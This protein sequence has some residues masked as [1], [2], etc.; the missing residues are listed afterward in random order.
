VH[1]HIASIVEHSVVGERVLTPQGLA[2]VGLG[3][4]CL[5]AVTPQ[6]AGE[7]GA[8]LRPEFGA[9]EATDLMHL[10]DNHQ[11]VRGL[12]E[13]RFKDPHSGKPY[14]LQISHR[15]LFAFYEQRFLLE[16]ELPANLMG[17]FSRGVAEL[18]EQG[19][20][21][22]RVL[23]GYKELRERY[24]QKLDQLMQL[25]TR[26]GHS[27]DSRAPDVAGMPDVALMV[28]DLVEE[29]Q[30]LWRLLPWTLKQSVRPVRN[31]NAELV[32]C[33]DPQPSHTL[34]FAM[35]PQTGEVV[36]E[37]LQRYDPSNPHKS[38]ESIVQLRQALALSYVQPHHSCAMA[39][40]LS[41]SAFIEHYPSLIAP[42]GQQEAVHGD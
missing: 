39:S 41:A 3:R 37:H 11:L 34:L 32:S 20:V 12:L 35:R 42:L 18:L 33:A 23:S 5:D 28:E 10:K 29:M 13:L 31:E 38:L 16:P 22:L 19:Y 36:Y 7:L 27:T 26:E 2:D 1:D 15:L 14:L 8:L 6:K 30:A 24:D 25:A 9:I 4:I 17:L 21:P 40:G